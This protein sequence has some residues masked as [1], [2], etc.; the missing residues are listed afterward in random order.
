[1]DS[2]VKKTGLT[3]GLIGAV[4][5]A[6]LH[7]YMWQVREVD[8]GLVSMALYL[9]P[10]LMGIGSQIQSKFKLNQFI[11]LR[12]GVL[13]YIVAIGIVFVLESLTIYLIF[14]VLDPSMQDVM[15]EAQREQYELRKER[16]ENIGEPMPADYSIGGFVASTALKFLIYTVFGIIMALV[17]KKKPAAA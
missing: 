17:I 13:A 4:I 8:N 6:A 2:T 15:A 14:K 3:Y 16:G 7:M 1:M 9:I 5:V 12:Q 11:S 10:L